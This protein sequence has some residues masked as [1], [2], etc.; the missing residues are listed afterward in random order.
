MKPLCQPSSCCGSP[1]EAALQIPL[2][3]RVKNAHHREPTAD[4]PKIDELHGWQGCRQKHGSDKASSVVRAPY[5]KDA[6]KIPK[7][8]QAGANYFRVTTPWVRSCGSRRSIRLQKFLMRVLA[9]QSIDCLEDYYFIIMLTS[10]PYRFRGRATLS[11]RLLRR[12]RR[13]SKRNDLQSAGDSN[14]GASE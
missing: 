2:P 7:E 1:R 12:N 4:K 9:S 10:R 6:S 14:S 11:P 5:R 13:T 8:S 3:N